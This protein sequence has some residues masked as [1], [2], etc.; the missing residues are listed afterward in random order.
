MACNNCIHNGICLI[1][2]NEVTDEFENVEDCEHFKDKD[3]VVVLPCKVGDI[4]YVIKRCRC[5]KPENYDL[6]VCGRKIVSKT[7]KVLARVM[8]QETGKRIKPNYTGKIEFEV[9]PKGTICYSLY[10]KQFTL[11]ML[12]EIGKT[13]FPTRE[14]AEQALKGGAE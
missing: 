7:P 13:V 10:E 8:Y 2:Y 4:V 11:K 5:G 3:K 9:A 1:S 12:T 6:K 14:E